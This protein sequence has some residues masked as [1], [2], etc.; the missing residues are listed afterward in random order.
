MQVDDVDLSAFDEEQLVE[1]YRLLKTKTELAPD[2]REIAR[3]SQLPPHEQVPGLSWSTWL[4]MTGRGFGKTRTAAETVRIAVEEWGHKYVGL[5]GPTAGDLRDIMI[6]G[7]SGLLACYDAGG[8]KPPVYESSKSRIT[9]PNGAQANLRSADEPR[10]VRGLQFTFLWADE[11]CA[12]QYPSTWRLAQ[13]GNRLKSPKPQAVVTTTPLVGHELLQELIA[14]PRTFVTRGTMRDNAANLS[15]E[16]II[17]LEEEYGGTELGRQEL[18]GELL[19]TIPGALWD[20]QWFRREGFRVPQMLGYFD[21]ST[22][23]YIQT[24]RETRDLIAIEAKRHVRLR[25][26]KRVPFARIVVAVDPNV[27]DPEKKNNPLKKPD[28]CGIAV[29]GMTERGTPVVLGDFTAIIAPE[30]WARL[31]IQLSNACALRGDPATIVAETNNGGDLVRLAL[32]GVASKFPYQEVKAKDDKRTRAE[33]VSI[34]YEQGRVKHAGEFAML[35]KQMTTWDPTNTGAKS[36]NNI[37]ALVWGFA[38]L[39][40]G[41]VP[42]KSVSR[43]VSRTF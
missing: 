40:Y 6:E 17:E 42:R 12:W 20:P 4:I 10:R 34:L 28:A 7:E 37:D 35:E 14:N 26:D 41:R 15:E 24:P 38:A 8:G 36:P 19:T 29:V 1:F 9:W 33:P 43:M 2:W 31:A 11:I 18:D 23:E 32:Q 22:N 25:L 3:K 30:R 5:I 16:R 21:E 39:G 13:F 27:T